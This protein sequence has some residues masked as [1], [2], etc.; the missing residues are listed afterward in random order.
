MLA[1]TNNLKG[2]N[3]VHLVEINHTAVY[4]ING[5]HKEIPASSVDEIHNDYSFVNG[6]YLNTIES[7]IH[8]LQNRLLSPFA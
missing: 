5:S 3:E 7:L 2:K 1:I 6:N 4:Q 8:N